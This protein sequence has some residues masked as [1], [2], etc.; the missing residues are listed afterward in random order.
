[1]K[2]ERRKRYIRSNVQGYIGSRRLQRTFSDQLRR[3][4]KRLECVVKRIEQL[5]KRLMKANEASEIFSFSLCLLQWKPE[6]ERIC[7]MYRCKNRHS[8]LIV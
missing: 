5:T 8:S 1:M 2:V 3:F 6:S 7:M 4:L